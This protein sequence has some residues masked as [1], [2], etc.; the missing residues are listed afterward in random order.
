MLEDANVKF[1]L[2]A[3]GAVPP[4]GGLTRD[5]LIQV[6]EDRFDIDVLEYM[7]LINSYFDKWYE[8]N[9]DRFHCAHMTRKGVAYSAF[10]EGYNL[11]KED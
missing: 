6:C 4:L 7:D 1:R 2:I 5:E 3:E 10:L 9:R 8:E 11:L